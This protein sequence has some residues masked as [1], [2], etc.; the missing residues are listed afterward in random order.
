MRDKVL[1]ACRAL[2]SP[3]E[4]VVCALSGGGDSV[5]LLH[6]L[7]SLQEELDIKVQAA[8]FNHCL[9]GAESDGDEAFVRQLCREW[10]VPLEV[11]RGDPRSLK[12]QSPE[13]AARNL[14]YDFLQTQPGFIA[15]A[16]HADDQL[17]TVL[18]N[19]L[20][21]TGLR[22]LG[23]M[24][25]KQGKV[26]RPM[27]AVCRQEIDQ[28]LTGY[29]LPYRLDSTNDENDALRNRLRHEV[30][31][32]LHRENPELAAAVTRMTALLQD[33]EAY[34]NRQTELLLERA[35]T[36]GGYSCAA[37]LE[38][39]AVLRRRAIRA[40]LP[41]PK[42]SMTHVDAVEALLTGT[43]SAQAHLS[44]GVTALREYDILRFVTEEK[45]ADFAPVFLK[46]G[47]KVWLPGAEMW[48]A[49]QKETAKPGDFAF[50]T[51]D[52]AVCIRPRQTGDALHLSGGTKTVKKWM[53]DRKIP[54]AQRTALP[55][56]ADSRGVIGVCGL[57]MDVTRAAVP[58][59]PAWIVQFWK[60]GSSCNDR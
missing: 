52:E 44:G 21:G 32:L 23:G 20:R 28:Y 14:R 27:L 26:I 45:P 13:E 19:L 1:A 47:E 8:H 30:T 10:N 53:I 43:G 24:R 12:G 6:C 33:D 22:G 36:D 4:T 31:P 51:A 38:A 54:A 5:A 39:E 50:V 41:C 40:I 16:H 3:G 17:E 18:L 42:P 59:T 60:E 35:E 55:L 34:L 46:P 15:T 7:L 25:P 11:G 9:R 37:L 58:G 56:V 2:T 48:C 29:D 57:G 49:V